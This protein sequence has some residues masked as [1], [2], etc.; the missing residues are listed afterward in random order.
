MPSSPASVLVRPQ[1]GWVF[2]TL[3]TVSDILKFIDS[4]LIFHRDA[5]LGG[6]GLPTSL[7][8]VRT[9]PEMVVYVSH[10][11]RPCDGWR[12]P[13]VRRVPLQDA[14]AYVLLV[15]VLVQ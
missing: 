5:R 13:S 6:Y 15:A 12:P 1:P 14:R 10:P 8:T 3:A 7:D 11:P 4:K 2:F 9:T